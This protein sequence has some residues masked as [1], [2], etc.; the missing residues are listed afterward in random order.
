MDFQ[1]LV[2]ENEHDGFQGPTSYYF[3]VELN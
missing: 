2:G 1:L 3:F